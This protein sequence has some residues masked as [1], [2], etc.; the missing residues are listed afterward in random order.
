VAVKLSRIDVGR[1]EKELV[2]NE[3]SLHLTSP[4]KWGRIKE[5]GIFNERRAGSSR[6]D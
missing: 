6:E 4:H 5:R 2:F 3:E 1:A